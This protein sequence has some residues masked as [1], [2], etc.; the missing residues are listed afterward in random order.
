MSSMRTLMRTALAF[1]VVVV[2][3][4]PTRAELVASYGHEN[5]TNRLQDDTGNGHTLIDHGGVGFVA[6]PVQT[7]ERFD[8]GDTVAQYPYS[9]SKYLEVPEGVITAGSDFT[10]T[11]LVR[12]DDGLTLDTGHQTILASNWFRFQ[13]CIDRDY[14]TTPTT[15]YPERQ[16]LT[17]GVKDSESGATSTGNS[18]AG[19]FMAGEWYFVA[20]RFDRSENTFEAFIQQPSP[21]LAAAA[22]NFTPSFTVGDF[23]SL[24]LGIDGVSTIG[25]TDPFGGNI[26]SARFYSTVLSDTEL[27][28]VLHEFYVV[29][30]P[31]TLLLLVL[32]LGGM[33]FLKNRRRT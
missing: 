17:L 25:G 5:P 22:V 20:L 2:V 30:E 10:F 9:S 3:A 12:R 6:A 16:R 24:R 13:W 32:G 21:T 8:L 29:P 7:G 26:D 11:A 15:I 1:L 23:S 33:P 28:S 14:S 31:S 18:A 27:E 4:L 19:T